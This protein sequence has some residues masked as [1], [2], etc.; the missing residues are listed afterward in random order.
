[1]R[2]ICVAIVFAT[3]FTI[4]SPR[5]WAQ[6]RQSFDMAVPVAPSPVVIDGQQWLI[7]ELHLTNFSSEPLRLLKVE[8]LA[9]SDQ[10]SLLSYGSEEIA[11]HLAA[12]SSTKVA[13]LAIQ[14]G[15]QAIVYME[16]PLP[17]GVQPRGLR[18]RVEYASV[19]SSE[20][21]RVIGGRCDVP[22]RARIALGPPLRGGPWAAVYHWQWPRGH[23]RVFYTL[24]GRARL[25]GRFAIDW[26]KL[27]DSGQLADADPDIAKNAFGYGV[28]VLAVADA[29]V[30]AVRD[31]V[32]EN[33][34]V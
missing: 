5:A 28:D 9:S 20:T 12:P 18:H 23:R 29:R 10:E 30:A 1:M 3:I 21:A 6:A 15:Q 25:P 34:R 27:N 24:D 17:A 4:V 13:S 14:S 19:G 16:V 33:E 26:V 2:V 11:V 8:V 22:T 31:G 32:S 7:Y